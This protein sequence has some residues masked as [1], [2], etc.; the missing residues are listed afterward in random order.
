MPRYVGLGV[1]V[2]LIGLFGPL[3]AVLDAV[4][5]RVLV[6]M[7]WHL[8]CPFP[9]RFATSAHWGKWDVYWNEE[10]RCVDVCEP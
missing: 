1:R 10:M 3:L 2:R 9:L 6:E 7:V 8:A 5:P 4:L